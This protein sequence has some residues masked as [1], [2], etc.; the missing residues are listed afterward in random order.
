MIY[1]PY[2]STNRARRRPYGNFFD[3]QNGITTT[4]RRQR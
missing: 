3:T 1:S 4:P 2:P